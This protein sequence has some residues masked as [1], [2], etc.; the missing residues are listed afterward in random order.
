MSDIRENI[1]EIVMDAQTM[2]TREQAHTAFATAFAFPAEYGRNLD[3]LHDL[4]CSI[5]PT[6]LTLY[7][8]DCLAASLGRYGKVML[9]VLNDAAAENPLF[10]FR[11]VPEPPAAYSSP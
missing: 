5:P 8:S 7:H 9:Q 10:Q 2:T 3:A 11:A 1:R 6:R 4:L